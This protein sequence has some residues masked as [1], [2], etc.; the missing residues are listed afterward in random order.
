LK[1]T[2]LTLCAANV[3]FVSGAMAQNEPPRRQP[4]RAHLR[5]DLQDQLERLRL[6]E[7]WLTRQIDAMDRGEVPEQSGP[8]GE[9]PKP[10]RGVTPEERQKLMG[11]LRDLQSD[12]ALAGGD[13]PFK[14]IL[15]AQ[16]P[17]SER[18]IARLAPRLRN[19]VELKDADEERYAAARKEMVAGIQIARAARQFGLTARDPD[20]T[21]ESLNQARRVLRAAIAAGFDARAEMMRYEL[22]DAQ[23]RLDSLTQEIT[24]A[25]FERDARIDE[26]LR[27]MVKRIESS[28][29]WEDREIPPGKER[30]A[31]PSRDD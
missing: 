30:R 7:R 8:E 1:R 14:H 12:P 23:E 26:Q 21:D 4:D 28:D 17:E 27:N 31:R 5:Q 29:G 16:G 3:L 11:V 6:R 24:D 19:L 22:R 10:D 18:L 25:E 13:S 9:G 15:E 2:L 20:V